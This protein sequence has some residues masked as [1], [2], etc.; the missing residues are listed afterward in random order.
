MNI[1]NKPAYDE[2]LEMRNKG[3]TYTQIA[4]EFGVTKQWVNKILTTYYKGLKGQRGKGFDIEKIVYKG[5]YEHFKKNLFESVTSFT[6][7]VYEKGHNK[8]RFITDFITGESN[9]HL[10]LP[11]IQR[12]CEITGTTFE[13]CFKRRD[14]Q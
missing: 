7:K 8:V 6:D 3:F 9:S 4:E 1:D 14:V 11:Q 12:M 10:S 2:M 5:I 13:E